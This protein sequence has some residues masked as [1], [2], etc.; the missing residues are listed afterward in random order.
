MTY[1]KDITA[2]KEKTRGFCNTLVSLLIVFLFLGFSYFFSDELSAYVIS[3]LKLCFYTVIGSV[4]PFLILCDIILSFSHFDR[5]PLFRRVFTKL[6]NVNGY[7]VSAYICGVL[8]GFPIGMKVASELYNA[9]Y[10]SREE[11]ERLIGFSNNTGPSFVISG[12]GLGLRKSITDGFLLYISMIV[13]S[14]A[15][16]IILGIGKTPTDIAAVRKK[17]EFRLNLSIKNAALNTLN[18]CAFVVF[19]SVVCG[20]LKLWL[21]R[22]KIYPFLLPIFEVS[23]AARILAESQS[24][25]RGISLILTAFAVS[26]S[27]LSVHMQGHTFLQGFGISMKKYYIAKLMQGVFASLFILA[28]LVLSPALSG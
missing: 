16:G 26:F 28:I 1:P 12:I 25:T 21:G 2:R 15:V 20:V 19:F 4:F 14:I 18:I 3:G 13:S 10:I 6:F 8:C 24:L 5:A 23:N 11:C 27:G 22:L 7:A 9:G 17:E